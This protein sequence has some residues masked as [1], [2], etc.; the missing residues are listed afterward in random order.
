MWQ[1][2]GGFMAQFGEGDEAGPCY[3]VVLHYQGERVD[4]RERAVDAPGLLFVILTA[5]GLTV[6]NHRTAGRMHGTP[7][8]G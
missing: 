7:R 1:L 4:D 8:G 2:G 6:Y 3:S 5:G